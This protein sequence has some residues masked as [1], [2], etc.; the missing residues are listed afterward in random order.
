MME[1]KDQVCSLELAKKLEKLGFNG[2]TIFQWRVNW[3]AGDGGVESEEA[4]VV[5]Q[6]NYETKGDS[7]DGLSTQGSYLVWAPTV[8][9]LELLLPDRVNISYKSGKKRSN[10]HYLKMQRV[11]SGYRV[12]FLN[13]R[14]SSDSWL[15]QRD[16]NFA[17]AL[18]KMLIYL[19]EN[20]L[21][22]L[23]AQK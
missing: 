11:T 8:A 3:I 18:A 16:Q 13:S 4:S 15:E 19:I 1:L 22:T 12:A 10:D 2:P 17:N 5:F 9:E 20:G 21:I 6:E 7:E 14:Y 23:P